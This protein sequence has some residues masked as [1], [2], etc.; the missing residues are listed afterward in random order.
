VQSKDSDVDVLVKFDRKTFDNYMDLKFFLEDTLKT[1]VDLVLL[2][3]LK[4]QLKSQILDE[5]DYVKGL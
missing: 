1:K 5:V 2:D 4:P 3:T